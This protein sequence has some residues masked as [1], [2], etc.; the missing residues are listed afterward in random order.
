MPF[1]KG[2][3]ALHVRAE[4]KLFKANANTICCDDKVLRRR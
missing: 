2:S 1:K 3:N 4:R